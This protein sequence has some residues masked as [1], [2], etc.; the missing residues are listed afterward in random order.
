M[1]CD[2]VAPTAT[3]PNARLVVLTPNVGGWPTPTSIVK[4]CA[5]SP[6]LAVSVT[7]CG[8]LVLAT[9]ALKLTLLPPAAIVTAAGTE[10]A[11]LLLVRFTVK[12]LLAAAVFK[13]TVQRSD[14]APDM[15]P[16]AQLN[17]VTTGTPV[18]VSP[19]CLGRLSDE[20]LVSVSC[21]V[22]LP[23]VKGLN[24]TLTLAVSP[25]FNVRGKF[26]P[27]AA[28]PVPVNVAAFTV[29][30]DVPVDE[31]VSV[32]VAVVVTSTLPKLMLDALTVRM[33]AAAC[34]CKE[35]L[36]ARLPAL[37]IKR[38]FC[39]VGT[40]VMFALKLTLLAPAATV[41]VA[42]TDTAASLLL[43]ATVNPP[44]PAGE[45]RATV[46]G[47]VAEPIT[48]EFAQVSELKVPS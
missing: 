32:S 43:R 15:V 1:V 27:E 18:A 35:K 21:P 36:W 10:T 12:P 4:L 16:W 44:S 8:V 14:P 46:Q 23:A 25:G 40:A 22:T 30:D 26:A 20:L 42:G 19:T 29:T 7:Y 2:A 6:E 38:T 11:A 41:T 31:R 34:N 39:A 45:P 9:V 3:L 33:E 47:S 37:A 5:R 13:V 17:P 48:V 28:N 24:W